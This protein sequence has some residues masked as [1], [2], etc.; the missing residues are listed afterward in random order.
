MSR[1]RA[2][3]AGD[4]RAIHRRN[5]ALSA[6]S[7]AMPST[8]PTASTSQIMLALRQRYK[9]SLIG[10]R[11]R[12]DTGRRVGNR[13]PVARSHDVRA[14]RERQDDPS[15]KDIEFKGRARAPTKGG[16]DLRRDEPLRH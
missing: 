8:N 9:A 6:S 7:V 12:R 15:L 5:A 10:P 4:W 14:E 1:S 13:Q 11:K 2:R 16:A 3:S